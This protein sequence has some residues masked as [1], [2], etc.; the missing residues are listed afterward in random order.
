[1]LHQK[2]GNESFIG[3]PY[4]SISLQFNAEFAKAA[5]KL[6]KE[7]EDPKILSE[8]KPLIIK[9][10]PL[11]VAISFHKTD[12]GITYDETGVL[13]G[14]YTFIVEI[15]ASEQN[16]TLEKPPKLWIRIPGSCYG[17]LGTDGRGHDNAITIM[18]GSQ[19]ALLISIT[20]GVA[21]VI[22]G[23]TYGMISAYAGGIVDEVVQRNNEI[24]Y[25]L[26]ALPFLIL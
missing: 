18:L 15:E 4:T 24:V 13:K 16:V 12:P 9:G 2:L 8:M 10:T 6:L 11:S 20:Y 5:I 7:F 1:M 19:L 25:S 26:P 17:I 21:V 3:E 22:V 23:P 14:N